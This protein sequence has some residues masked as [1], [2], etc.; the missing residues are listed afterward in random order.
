MYIVQYGYVYIV[1][2]CVFLQQPRRFVEG[3]REVI[4]KEQQDKDTTATAAWW[5]TTL[6]S[7]AC[8]AGWLLFI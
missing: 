5:L 1:C 6:F 7:H 2:A 4:K 8:L 3:G